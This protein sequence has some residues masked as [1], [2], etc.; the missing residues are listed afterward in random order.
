[1][2]RQQ[3]TSATIKTA[4]KKK[5]PL[6][7]N[8][9]KGKNRSKAKNAASKNCRKQKLPQTSFLLKKIAAKDESL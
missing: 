8:H 6:S 3:G 2:Q 4:A 1:M 7:K 5:P 9:R